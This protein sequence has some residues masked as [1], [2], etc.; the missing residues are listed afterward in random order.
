MKYLLFFL[1]LILWGSEPLSSWHDTSTKTDIVSY[2]NDVTNPKSKNFIAPE[3]RI[4]VLDNDGTLWSE[5][6]LYFQLAFVIDQIKTMV[7]EH[8]EWKET[9]P[10]AAV[11]NNDMQALHHAGK[12]GL[13]QL[14]YATHANMDEADFRK[15]VSQ[16]LKT[17]K[18]PRFK[19]AYTELVYQPMLELLEYLRAHEF[20][21]FIVSGGGVD[22]MRVW[23]SEIYKIPS[24]HI[25]GSRFEVSYKE[26]KIMK[27]P[28]ILHINDK[29][30][31]PVGIYQSIG[32]RPVIAV[33]NSDGDFAMMR[34]TE[35]SHHHTMQLL[36]HHT[37]A[38][39][40]YAYDKSSSIG[41][42]DKALDY[43]KTHHWNVVDMQ[44]DWKV[45]YPHEKVND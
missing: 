12:K 10:F 24:E 34:Y 20:T 29:E 38:T 1:P 5:Q 23:A 17:A 25:I 31:K 9:Q 30:G 15:K 2:V 27:E 22:F 26:G 43:A 42:L 18:H 13:M 4:V 16:W 21:P 39:R 36:I 3:D 44:K 41:K 6:P 7:P 33:G 19:R 14:L 8:P 11:L 37:D 35:D 45:I 40:E 28:N 32:K